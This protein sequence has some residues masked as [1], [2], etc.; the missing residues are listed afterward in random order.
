MNNID[1]KLNIN[2]AISA[3]IT[4][5]SRIHMSQFKNMPGYIIHY[6]D[7]DSVVSNKPLPDSFYGAR[8]GQIKREYH[9]VE[10]VFLGPKLYAI[11]TKEKGLILKVAGLNKAAKKFLTFNDMLSLLF[12]PNLVKPQTRWQRNPRE[13]V[14]YLLDQLFTLSASSSKRLII[15]DS[16]G[17]FIDTEP[18][19]LRNGIIQYQISSLAYNR[20]L[21][22][23]SS[24]SFLITLYSA[25]LLAITL[26]PTNALI[27]YQPK[28]LALVLYQPKSLALF[29]INL[30]I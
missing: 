28:P 13:G 4:A 10:G 16:N 20:Y 11:V 3:A 30:N 6:S 9:I 7:T 12:E 2:V 22:W 25:K 26:S 17:R 15:R 18:Y 14:I 27:L 5:Y 24:K 8:L 23:L 1:K 19:E 21:D 29:Y